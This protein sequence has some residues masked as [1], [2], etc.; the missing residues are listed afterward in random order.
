MKKS[1]VLWAFLAFV[2]AVLVNEKG[3]LDAKSEDGGL[4]K[5]EH[6][7]AQSL[8]E[9]NRETFVT[10]FSAEQRKHV[11]ESKGI[12]PNDA[13][14]AVENELVVQ[15]IQNNDFAETTQVR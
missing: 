4:S 6:L 11:I 12:D 13:V 3:R 7:F 5:E 2:V 9:R 10:Q 14:R 15:V 1:L 8:T